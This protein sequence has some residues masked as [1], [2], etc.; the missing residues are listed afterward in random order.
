[1]S[2]DYQAVKKIERIIVNEYLQYLNETGEE[3]TIEPWITLQYFNHY[4]R[5]KTSYV[6]EVD[7][8]VV[9]FIFAQP[10]SYIHSV[11]RE[12]WLEYIAVLPEIRKKGIGSRLISEVIDYA[13]THGFTLLYTTLNPNNNESI[14]FLMKHGFE[15]RDWKEANKKLKRR[16]A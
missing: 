14:R 1:M 2:K 10:T 12:I 6:A 3:D 7:H 16:V 4:A 11:R 9:G 15:I 13:N 8:K 5:T